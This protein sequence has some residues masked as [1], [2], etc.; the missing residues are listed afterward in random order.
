MALAEMFPIAETRAPNA[1]AKAVDAVAET[2]V[3]SA[4]FFS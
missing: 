1:I 3:R 4:G 2:A